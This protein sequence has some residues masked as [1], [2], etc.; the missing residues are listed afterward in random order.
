MSLDTLRA[1]LP[2]RLAENRQTPPLRIVIE[3]NV[4]SLR[5][6]IGDRSPQQ[7][8]VLST[9]PPKSRGK[10]L[11]ATRSCTAVHSPWRLGVRRLDSRPIFRA[12]RNHERA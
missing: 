3:I 5:F 9:S 10:R 6:M 7:D 4:G 1:Y 8:P 2:A 12:P 11:F